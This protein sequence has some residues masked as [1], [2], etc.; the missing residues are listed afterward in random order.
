MESAAMLH[1][2]PFSQVSP[3]ALEA[4]SELWLQVAEMW[5]TWHRWSTSFHGPGA[6]ASPTLI[7]ISFS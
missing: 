1:T 3:R 6:D 5:L 2:R 4:T 7:Y